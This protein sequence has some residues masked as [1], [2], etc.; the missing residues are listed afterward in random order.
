MGS[1]PSF[2]PPS[3]R[4]PQYLQPT[5]KQNAQQKVVAGLGETLAG[6]HPGRP[7][8]FV[9]AP[10]GSA[11]R[12]LALPS[13]RTGL[14]VPGTP[15]SVAGA[16]AAAAGHDGGGAA[17]QKQ[18]AAPPPPPPVWLI[19]RSDT[20]GED[21]EGCA[22][23]GLYDSVPVRPLEERALDY[24]GTMP[25]ASLAAD[26]HASDCSGDGSGGSGGDGTGDGS[27]DGG[28]PLLWDAEFRRA[29]V[30]GLLEVAAAAEAALGG[31]PQDVEGAWVAPGRFAVVQ[32]RPQ[33]LPGAGTA[34]AGAAA[35]AA[36]GAA[37]GGFRSAR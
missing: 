21:L 17:G 27:A 30:D 2:Q 18:A 4:E 16:P 1:C 35:A 8:A 15:L 3:T 11:T 12:I 31:L 29:L 34:A 22:G 10:D 24:A 6:N 28:E 25:T 32:S 13:K 19:A 33:V 20:T 37:S 36:G 23:A 14:F 9:D 7:L 5:K 26:A